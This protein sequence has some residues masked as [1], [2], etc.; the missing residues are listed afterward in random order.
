MVAEFRAMTKEDFITQQPVR[1]R[2]NSDN[3]SILDATKT[4]SNIG[5]SD[6][7]ESGK[8]WWS[9]EMQYSRTYIKLVAPTFNYVLGLSNASLLFKLLGVRSAEAEK[10]TKFS[11]VYDLTEECLIPLD[12]AVPGRPYLY[13]A[14]IAEHFI[15][16]FDFEKGIEDCIYS[17][18]GNVVKD[19]VSPRSVFDINRNKQGM[20]I[21]GDYYATWDDDDLK[22]A[23]KRTVE[24]EDIQMT[25]QNALLHGP[26]ERFTLLYNMKGNK[27]RLYGMLNYYVMVPP[28]ELRPRVGKRDHAI[29]IMFANVASANDELGIT[30]N[31][32]TPKTIVASYRRLDTAVS[33]A[34]YKLEGK[35]NTKIGD[36]SMLERIKS[37]QGQIRKNN[38]GR[39]Q[40]YSGRAVVTINPYL[41]LDVI[42]VPKAM[43]PKLFGY[44][45]LPYYVKQVD[46]E[47]YN[48][49]QG[50]KT[51]KKDKPY[52]T[53][54]KEF[55]E[56]QKLLEIIIENKIYEK[57]PVVLGRQPTLHKQSLQGFHCEISETNTIE[58]NPLVCPA[59]NMDFD[60]DQ[61]HIE[62]PLSPEAIREV[63]ELMMTTQNLFLAKDGS[64]TTVP[65]MDM[66][67]GLYILTSN[68]YQL[69]RSVATYH[70]LEEVRQDVMKHKISPKDTIFVS[71]EALTCLAG[72]AAF[73]ACFPKNSIMPRGKA[74]QPGQLSVKQV[75]KNTIGE[76]VAFITRVDANGNFVMPLGTGYAPNT[77]VVGVI[78]RLVETGF[79]VARLYPPNM[80]MLQ[81]SLLNLSNQ[82]VLDRFHKNV[83]DIDFYYNLGLETHDRYNLQYENEVVEVMKYYK[84]D[85]VNTLEDNNGYKM[86][87]QSGAR[88][89]A[90]NLA[91][92]FGIKGRVQKNDSESFDAII[93][94]AYAKQLT[95]LEHFV[96]AYG[97]RQGQMDKS[98]KTG[99]TGYAMRKMWHTDQEMTIVTADCGTKD[100]LVI[101][102]TELRALSN[103]DTEDAIRDEVKS[104][105]RHAITGR[106]NA[107]TGNFIGELVADKL[108]EDDSVES[109]TIRSPLHCKK[110][111]CQKC[112]GIDWSTHKLAVIGLPV[113]LIAA[114]SIGEPGTQLTMKQFQKGGVA[115]KSTITSAFDK[116]SKYLDIADLGE[117]YRDGKY[118]G[119]DPIAWGDGE[120]VE[121][122]S[123]DINKKIV[124]IEGYSKRIV[125]P[126]DLVLKTTATKGRGLSADHGD[127]SLPEL[128]RYAGIS[129]AQMY[130]I[131]KL[132]NLY[133]SEVNIKMAHFETLIAAMT[134]YMV[135]A[136]DR[137]D[138][139][140]G[141][142]CTC[143]ELYAGPTQN[144]IV[145]PRLIS[146][147]QAPSASMAALDD[148]IMEFQSAGLARIC[149]LGLT[150]QLTKP[151]NAMVMSQT[152]SCGSRVNGFIEQRTE[153]V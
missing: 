110:P 22:A 67:Y 116:V 115:S 57:V 41:P 94:N 14:Q 36:R 118:S 120:I 132:Y 133:K 112:Y 95:P 151:L 140:V 143:G 147:K 144:T 33:R 47:E 38:L 54:L 40:D 51:K 25:V 19:S 34:Q 65:R 21:A 77:T 71:T 135:V 124:R 45:A 58:V 142:Y 52:L 50:I 141:Q 97:G 109:V 26:M 73:M 102:K 15:K 7:A 153:R 62:I 78:N 88:G 149:A 101:S 137:K 27:D 79:R 74:V 117:L 63:F 48:E 3:V 123:R 70:S 39:R 83:E 146:T 108:T 121:E 10:I 111:C 131:F 72:D 30:I 92:T 126:E 9:D 114:Q 87:M 84:K 4:V 152:I 100:G 32:I 17:A 24:F 46:L 86:L 76:Y 125:V 89:N 6:N 96:D 23:K 53:R 130:A 127:Y 1:S 66:L 113:G 28:Y 42:K 134:R 103:A 35:P 59:F 91:Q 85:L 138:L 5:L 44:H 139:M 150:D 119:Y 16:N 80:S 107:E 104:M 90:E 18:L 31:T 60:G 68:E 13:G 136:T 106:Y 75:D 56:Q 20:L 105:F 82:T 43:L 37:K 55:K 8:L 122:L 49:K 148:I 98:L 81:P 12:E 93:E 64:V 145:I 11:H 69:G 99:D 2:M 129:Y 61:G 29:S 128:L